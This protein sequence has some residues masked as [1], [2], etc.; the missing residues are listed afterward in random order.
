MKEGVREVN[1]LQV[2]LDS[3][4]ET[5]GRF[6]EG[7]DEDEEETGGELEEE[8]EFSG[9]SAAASSRLL[10]SLATGECGVGGRMLGSNLD[11]ISLSEDKETQQKH[12]VIIGKAETVIK[13]RDKTYNS[14]CS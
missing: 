6:G 1:K 10:A 7:E 5:Q 12:K 2:S 11:A 13:K 8:E 9:S 14:S 4:V 3:S